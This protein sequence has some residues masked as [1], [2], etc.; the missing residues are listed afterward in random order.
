MAPLS[1]EAS[2][3]VA[4]HL[5]LVGSAVVRYLKKRGF[6]N[7]VLRTKQ[8][9]DLRIQRDVQVLFETCKLDYV[10]LAA[11]RVGGIGAN[12]KFPTEFLLENLQIEMN[13]ISEAARAGVKKLIFLGSSCIYP[14]N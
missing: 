12:S 7:L 3:Y 1:K 13:V 9:L 8:E 5:G 4:G 11:A 10:I 6:K 2:I 14:K